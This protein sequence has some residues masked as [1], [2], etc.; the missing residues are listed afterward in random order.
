MRLVYQPQVDIQTGDVTGFEA[1]VRW[2]HP[3]N[4]AI[5]PSVFIPVAEESGLILQIGEWVMRKACA[6]AASWKSKLSVAV[7]VSA[8]QMQ[9]AYLPQMI[10]EML[11]ADRPL[12]VSPGS[13]NHRDG[14]GPRHQPRR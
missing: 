9:S 3:E 11:F 1:L 8:V 6:D 2:D 14:A 13:R 5:P 4:G 7:N 12:P 10:T